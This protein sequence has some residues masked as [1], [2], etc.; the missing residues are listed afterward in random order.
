MSSK[1]ES[2]EFVEVGPRDGLQNETT[3][4]STAQK[5]ELC[6]RLIAAGVRRLE[7]ASFAHP[8]RVPQMADA[9]AVIAGVP[10]RT[11]LTR[12]G[13]VLNK[14]G[15]LR[16]FATDIEELGLVCAVSESFSQ[17]NQGQS[18]AELADSAREVVRL[19]KAEGR[20]AQV[21]VSTAFACPFE[22]FIDPQR[23]LELAKRLAE[24]EPAEIA[25]ADTIGAA[26]PGP[27]AELFARVREAIA[28]LPLRAHFHNTRNT[29]LA[30]L[31]AAVQA[32]AS[33]VDASIGGLGGCPFAP[34]ATGNVPSE[35]A[36][37]LLEQSGIR[38][39][40]Q[41]QAMIDT[42]RWLSEQMGK[43]LPGLLAR[44][45]LFPAPP[46]ACA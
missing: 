2:I 11:G 14:R 13:L 38:T 22:G 28:P 40:I 39:G 20:R 12:I 1:I 25:L 46:V 32:G 41:L 3:P 34:G 5:I 17:R 24:A 33:V 37:Y 16:A 45:G 15:A 30:N 42:S 27:V 4:F 21:T 29:G 23:T 6:E 43:P 35:D 26:A 7:I 19:A 10:A 9:E 18:V 44:A 31:W 36:L 8:T